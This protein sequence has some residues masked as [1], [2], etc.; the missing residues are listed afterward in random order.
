MYSTANKIHGNRIENYSIL[1]ASSAPIARLFLS[2][3][4]DYRHNHNEFEM[5]R[6]RRDKSNSTT[7]TG[8]S[9]N[10]GNPVYGWEPF[11]EGYNSR[12]SKASL[13]AHLLDGC[14]QVKTDILVEVDKRQSRSLFKS[15]QAP[16]SPKVEDIKD[17]E[18]RLERQI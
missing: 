10:S 2:T 13:P 8:S 11:S 12:V 15:W 6:H 17:V 16:K 4:I 1:L 9:Y 14:V 5:H 7:F 18:A 3:L